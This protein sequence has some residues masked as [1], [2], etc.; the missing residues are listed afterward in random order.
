MVPEL[1]EALLGL[2]VV[3]GDPVA[4]ACRPPRRGRRRPCPSTRSRCARPRPR[5]GRP[6]GRPRAGRRSSAGWR[7]RAP[8]GRGRSRRSSRRRARSGRGGRAAPPAAA[9]GSPRRIPSLSASSCRDGP[10]GPSNVTPSL[11]SRWKLPSSATLNRPRSTSRAR[12][13]TG[14]PLG[15]EQLLTAP[16]K[17]LPRPSS[18]T[19]R[20]PSCAEPGRSWRRPPPR[21][22]SRPSA[23][24]SG[25]CPHG[26]RDRAEPVGLGE[27]R[28]GEE[29]T[30][31]GRGGGARSCGRLGAAA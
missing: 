31:R 17:T 26:Y 2:R 29:A 11:C 3:P 4:R 7:S 16:L 1:L 12:S 18:S 19:P 27:L 8:A 25:T 22:A 10:R 5:S 21:W 23:T 15:R 14:E 9:A 6:R 28:L 30:V 24:C 20:S 13:A